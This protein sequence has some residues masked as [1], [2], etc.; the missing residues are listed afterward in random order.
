[1]A[2]FRGPRLHSGPFSYT[3]VKKIKARKLRILQKRAEITSRIMEHN[4]IIIHCTTKELH[5]HRHRH[6]DIK[7]ADEA[8]IALSSNGHF[9]TESPMSRSAISLNR[10]SID[11]SYGNSLANHDPGRIIRINCVRLN[12]HCDTCLLPPLRGSTEVGTLYLRV[13]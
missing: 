2:I 3:M 6:T 13:L 1:M 9:T 8:F 5:I 10:L 4:N 12:R 7:S 11:F